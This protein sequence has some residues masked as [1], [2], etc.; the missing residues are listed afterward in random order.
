MTAFGMGVLTS[1]AIAADVSIKGNVS[2]TLTASNNYFLGTSPSGGTGQTLSAGTLD[3]LVRTPTTNYFLDTYFSY[4][5]FFGPGAADTSLT[6]GT[7]AHANFT[8]D[9]TD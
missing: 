9:H 7:P 3:V 8:V 5:K 6:W 4:Y 1:S 2:E